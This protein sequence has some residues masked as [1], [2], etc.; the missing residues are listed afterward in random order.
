MYSHFP[1][2]VLTNADRSGNNRYFVRAKRVKVRE[3]WGATADFAQQNTFGRRLIHPASIWKTHT[4]AQFL[5]SLEYINRI[6]QQIFFLITGPLEFEALSASSIGFPTLFFG[7][8]GSLCLDSCCFLSAFF[9][10]VPNLNF[11]LPIHLISYRIF[12]SAYI[13]K[14][15][16]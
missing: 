13:S 11:R 5:K 4:R 8:P 10:P 7:L 6:L 12:K 15:T 1:T 3:C 2:E 16:F 9:R 14:Q